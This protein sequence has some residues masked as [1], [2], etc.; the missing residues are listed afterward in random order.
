MSLRADSLPSREE[1]AP[2]AEPGLLTVLLIFW[3]AVAAAVCL[4]R[5]LHP[6]AFARWDPDSLMHLVQLRDLLAGQGWFDMVQHRLDPPQGVLMHWS[7]LID[8]PLAGLVLLGNLFGD[9][10]AFALTI[11]PLLLLLLLMG[12]SM[13]VAAALGGRRAGLLALVLQLLFVPL[14]LS[15]LPND[16]DHHNAQLAL[17]LAALAAALRVERPACAALAGLL[18][19]LMLAIG[20]ETLPYVA[21]IAL[22]VALRWALDGSAARGVALFGASAGLAPALL[23][24]AAGSPEAPFACDALSW[25][26]ALPGLVAGLGLAAITALPGGPRTVTGRFAWTGMVCVASATV[27]LVVAPE[28]RGGP[29]GMLSPELKSLWL[30]NISEAQP[31]GT[32]AARQPAAALALLGPPIVALGVALARRL[33]LPAAL[34]AVALGLSLYQVRTI[35]YADAVSVP[36]L[37]AWL[38]GVLARHGHAPRRRWRVAAAFLLASPLAYLPLGLAGVEAARLA[39]GGRLVPAQPLAAEQSGAASAAA[40]CLDSA[41]ASLLASVPPG[42]VMAPVL[43]GP[44]VLALSAHAV[45]GAPY[46]RGGAAILAAIGAMQAPPAAALAGLRARGV[47]YVAVCSTGADLVAI[48]AAAPHGLLAALMEGARISGLQTVEPGTATALRLW[49]V[50]PAATP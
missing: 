15:F 25:S 2:V 33:L 5:V 14:L 17:L 32:F 42:L 8:A 9:G 46:H 18:V 36:V 3:G 23:H 26:W 48:R 35:P 27:F 16:I 7:R 43:Q 4:L 38:A 31:L 28:C 39:S 20:L 44:A 50:R 41:S 45:V 10:E 49:R 34:L 30:E 1:T 40:Q 22:A 19:A 21:V 6:E 29:Y 12:G 37:A 13:A 47:D 24:L 11:W